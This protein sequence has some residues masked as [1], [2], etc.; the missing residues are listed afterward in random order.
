MVART[1]RTVITLVS[2]LWLALASAHDTT[3]T[4]H[5]EAFG[6]SLEHPADWEALE[7]GAE[8]NIVDLFDDSGLG[9]VSVSVYPLEDLADVLAALDEE[10][11]V[12]VL[13]EGQVVFVEDLVMRDGTP[14]QIAGVDA[15]V[16][17]FDGVSAQRAGAA[18]TGTLSVAMTDDLL[19][20]LFMQANTTAIEPYRTVFDGVAASFAL[21]R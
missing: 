15:W 16:R 11:L 21:A 7:G 19:V 13:L 12:D 14:I 5:N 2:T 17:H 3:V 4:Y 18:Q 10:A 20:V 9:F 1:I 8:R 6:F